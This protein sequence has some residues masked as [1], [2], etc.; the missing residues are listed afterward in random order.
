MERTFQT[1]RRAILMGAPA[2]AAFSVATP[3]AAM[4]ASDRGLQQAIAAYREASARCEHHHKTVY[5]PI[6]ARWRAACDAVPHRTTKG[7]FILVSGERTISTEDEA[8]V[9][10]CRRVLK[11]GISDSEYRQRCAELVSLADEREAQIAAI[12]RACRIAEELDRSEE[13]GDAASEA[14]AVVEEYPVRSFADLTAK[15]EIMDSLGFEEVPMGVLMADLR[16]I[17]A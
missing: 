11:D 14:L 4:P 17:K 15:L 5:E 13:L 3:L 10:V 8:A 7:K 16:R 12:S 9:A 6:Y 1:D 2:L